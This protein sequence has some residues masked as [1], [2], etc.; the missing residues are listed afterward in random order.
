MREDIKARLDEYTRMI[1]D[2]LSVIG[3]DIPEG[4]KS[5]CDAI[6][7]SLNIGGKRLRPVLALEFC[8]M[9]GG[10][11]SVSLRSACAIELVHTY[12]LIHDDLPCMDTAEEKNPA[13]RDLV[14]ILRCLREM[15]SILMLL[16]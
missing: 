8:R 12:S 5:V 13:I 1:N 15:R 7:Y 3:T 16:R 9:C 2:T 11:V 14:K 4:T 6:N 10:D